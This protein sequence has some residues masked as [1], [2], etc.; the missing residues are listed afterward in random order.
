MPKKGESLV[1]MEAENSSDG[2]V[3]VRS[4]AGVLEYGQVYH[5]GRLI[6]SFS[7]YKLRHSTLLHIASYRLYV[8]LGCIV[9][10]SSYSLHFYTE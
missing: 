8:L 4:N 1:F 5:Q 6:T 10:G 2:L 9:H 7:N 3:N